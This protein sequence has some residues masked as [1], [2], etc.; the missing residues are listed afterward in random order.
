MIWAPVGWRL[1][2]KLVRVSEYKYSSTIFSE[3]DQPDAPTFE[4]PHPATVLVQ[5]SEP[6]NA[7]PLVPAIQFIGPMSVS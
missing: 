5:R 3:I 7:S 2:R 1:A 4:V 6:C